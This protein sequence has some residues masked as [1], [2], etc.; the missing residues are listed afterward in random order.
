MHIKKEENSWGG[1][2]KVAGKVKYHAYQQIAID[3]NSDVHIVDIEM[4]DD[5]SKFIHYQKNDRLWV[6]QII[7]NNN[8]LLFA[9]LEFAKDKLYT[10]YN[11]SWPISPQ[12]YE[13]DLF[14]SKHDI[15]TDVK[16]VSNQLPEFRIYPNPGRENICIEFENNKKQHINLSVYD[17]AGRHIETLIDETKPPG[18]YRQL[19]KVTGNRKE[20]APGLYHLRLQLGRKTVTR[21]VEIIK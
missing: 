2:D 3:Q 19:W 6:S 21:T 17:M 16:K 11:K 9:D 20:N 18:V 4:A 14:F 1:S 12:V 5:S 15:I 7:D 13:S 10:V 8:I